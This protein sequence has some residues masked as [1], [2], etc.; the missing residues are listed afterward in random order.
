MYGLSQAGKPANDRL[1]THLGKSGY[2]QAKRAPGLFTHAYRP[3]IFSLVVDSF[4][5]Q[6]TG[7]EHQRQYHFQFRF[8]HCSQTLP[9]PASTRIDKISQDAGSDRSSLAI[10]EADFSSEPKLN[11]EQVYH[12]RLVSVAVTENLRLVLDGHGFD[13][14]IG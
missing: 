5:V 2:V 10:P 13:D 7:R 1:I 6:Y 14:T 9:P 11:L 4:G 3:I 12:N 8:Q